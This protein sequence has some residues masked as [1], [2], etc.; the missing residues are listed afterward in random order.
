MSYLPTIYV[1]EL[2]DC[3]P[4]AVRD[5][6]TLDALTSLLDLLDAAT[7]GSPGAP[8]LLG[9]SL[10]DDGS[11][12]DVLLMLGNCQL[13]SIS[14][15]AKILNSKGFSSVVCCSCSQVDSAGYL[16][17]YDAPVLIG[18]GITIASR[19]LTGR[20]LVGLPLAE[21]RREL[22]ESQK[23]LSAIAGYQVG[24]LA[25]MVSTFGHAVDG[26][27]LEEA[28][29]AGYRLILEAGGRVTDLSSNSNSPG[30]DRLDYR[31]VTTQNSP[32]SLADWI[33]GTGLSRQ[34]AQLREM[35]QRPRRI[36]SRLKL[37]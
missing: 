22:G 16:H 8:A 10:L 12:S 17:V 25:P 31:I 5:G 9:G 32:R 3:A 35:L 36:L 28:R 18:H 13:S 26:L 37:L 15:W 20:P 19:G 2:F 1:D 29:R 34:G 33:I 11:R 30:I 14:K 4:E 7:V 24:I 27:V 6:M 23:K 21:L